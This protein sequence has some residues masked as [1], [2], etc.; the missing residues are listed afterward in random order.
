[1]NRQDFTAYIQHP[2][3]IDRGIKDDLRGLA[4]RFP[5]CSSIQVLYTFLLHAANDHEVNFQLKKATAYVSSRKK[6]KELIKNTTTLETVS[7][8]QYPLPGSSQVFSITDN[9]DLR[10]P[11]KEEV[12]IEPVEPF[13][14]EQQGSLQGHEQTITASKFNF[15]ELIRKRLAEIEIEKQH[16]L[17]DEQSE[18]NQITLEQTEDLRTDLLSK[19]EIIEKFIREEPGISQSKVSFYK[20]SEYAEKSNIDNTDIVSETLAILYLNQGNIVKARM[21]YE[22]LSLLFPEKSSYFAAQIE[23]INS[24]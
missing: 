6:L 1:M 5:F 3:T 20:P 24:K 22:K 21:V 17:P 18:P 9:P 13:I 8:I 10:G 11:Q 15:T 12:K 2:H 4:E 23:K 16:I 14:G 19:E 7:V